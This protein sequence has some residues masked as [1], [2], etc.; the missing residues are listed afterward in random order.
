M[1]P[2][3]LAA[4]IMIPLWAW[5][6]P[7]SSSL[8][9]FSLLGLFPSLCFYM[10]LMR[11]IRGVP[12]FAGVLSLLL[13]LL[14]YGLLLSLWA[15]FGFRT[16]QPIL[17]STNSYLFLCILWPVWHLWGGYFCPSMEE[18]ASY[19]CLSIWSCTFLIGPKNSAVMKPMKRNFSSRKEAWSW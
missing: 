16:T 4:V 18:L 11:T 13:A 19:S 6:I 10:K 8:I 12:E 5:F 1:F 3:L 2:T 9:L 15:I 14:L 17:E 7:S